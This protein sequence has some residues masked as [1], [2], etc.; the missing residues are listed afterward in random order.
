MTLYHVSCL[1]FYPKCFKYV[2]CSHVPII[3]CLTTSGSSRQFA[4]FNTEM[5]AFIVN[6]IWERAQEFFPALKEFSVK[7]LS[8]QMNVRIGL[9]PYSKLPSES[10]KISIFLADL[11]LICLCQFQCPM[12]NQ[13]LVQFPV[14]P[15]YSLQAGMKE[16]ALAW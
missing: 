13:L 4:G 10:N 3:Y 12:A 1:L 14:C 9:R 6:R 2:L 15:A 8:E 16:E 7:N 5:N 11:V